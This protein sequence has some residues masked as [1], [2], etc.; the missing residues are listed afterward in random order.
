MLLRIF[1]TLLFF[2]IGFIH[3]CSDQSKTDDSTDQ[4]F[5]A[6]DGCLEDN[7][8]FVNLS[9]EKGISSPTSQYS[10]FFFTTTDSSFSSSNL[11]YNDFQSGKIYT[12]LVGESSDVSL[13]WTNGR[14]FLFNRATGNLNFRILTPIESG[15]KQSCQSATPKAS[16]GDAH[17]VI[18]IDSKHALITYGVKGQI[19]LID[20][21]TGKLVQEL[22]DFDV[23]KNALNSFSLFKWNSDT[24]LAPH[25][26]ISDDY[27]ATT[28]TESV[29]VLKYVDGVLSI[30]DQNEELDGNQGIKTTI[31]N[32]T[33]MKAETSDELIV[34]GL[35]GIYSPEGCTAG[36][37]SL[38]L[39]GNKWTSSSTWD[40]NES[41]L[42]SNGGVAFNSQSKIYASTIENA[43]KSISS[44]DLSSNQ[45]KSLHIFPA[46]SSGYAALFYD[47]STEAL[48]VGDS[49]GEKGQISV[50]SQEKLS[51]TTPVAGIPSNGVLIK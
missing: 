25:Q 48:Y 49:L 1:P 46:A 27:T 51:T 44:F 38:S 31:H 24:I 4:T 33:I 12:V 17:D 20:T 21:V 47:G 3:S 19:V 42:K 23:G 28:K 35:C 32:P 11:M 9:S 2:S 18:Q 29:F 34:F 26:G 22:R 41:S 43:I 13:S 6:E 15:F 45:S 10:G 7:L 50:Y 14:L 37:E 16:V 36:A 40:L 8:E 5:T 39:K 30:A